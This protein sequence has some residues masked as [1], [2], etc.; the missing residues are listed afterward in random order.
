MLNYSLLLL[1]L[2]TL[3][4]AT[5]DLEKLLAREVRPIPFL[6]SQS[7]LQRWLPVSD[8]NGRKTNLT[9]VSEQCQTDVQQWIAGLEAFAVEFDLCFVEKSPLCTNATKDDLKKNI[10]AL[11]RMV[12]QKR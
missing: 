4:T 1:C 5:T 9:G 6:V 10:Y 3:A 8:N 11:K 2:G 7:I 12:S